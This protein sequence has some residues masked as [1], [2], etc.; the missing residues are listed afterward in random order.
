MSPKE[1]RNAVWR[2]A[3]AVAAQAATAVTA[4]LVV[5]ALVAAYG[6]PVSDSDADDAVE[7]PFESTGQLRMLQLRTVTTVPVPYITQ[8]DVFISVKTSHQFHKSRLEVVLKTWFQLAKDQT[9]F[10]TDREDEELNARTSKRSQCVTD[11][12]RQM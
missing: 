3:A 11:T 4:A 8:S 12:L 2:R 6:K 5:L 9:W 1:R 7:T 10:F